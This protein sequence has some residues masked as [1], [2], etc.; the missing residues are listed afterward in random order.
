MKSSFSSSN[1]K[2]LQF[3]LHNHRLWWLWQIWGVSENIMDKSWE[4]LENIWKHLWTSEHT[5]NTSENV[6]RTSVTIESILRTSENIWGHL[7]RSENIYRTSENI[8]HHRQN[9]WE[10]I[11]V[12]Y[13]WIVAPKWWKS[14]ANQVLPVTR[15]ELLFFSLSLL[16]RC[17]ARNFGGYS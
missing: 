14:L 2:S 3:V 13:F 15:L 8:W 17:F 1:W 12:S 10:P 11:I 5:L 16:T 4:H 9:N 7:R 6:Y